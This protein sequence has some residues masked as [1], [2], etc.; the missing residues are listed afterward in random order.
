MTVAPEVT[1]AP[2]GRPL[3]GNPE[4][5]TPNLT[6]HTA[7]G[8]T[9]VEAAKDNDRE[10]VV[11]RGSD[12]DDDGSNFK[13]WQFVANVEATSAQQ[14]VRKAAETPGTSFLDPEGSV[15]LVAIPTRS[16]SPVTVTVKTTTTVVLS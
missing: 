8:I 13:S 12:G 3:S 15:T 4:A 7:G 5:S 10:Y 9:P 6:A 11:L 1:E 14:A 2:I 16:F